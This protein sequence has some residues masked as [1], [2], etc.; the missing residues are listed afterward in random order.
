MEQDI[1][2]MLLDTPIT[3]ETTVP[4]LYSGAESSENYEEVIIQELQ[5]LNHTEARN[6]M[7]L[8][9]MCCTIILALAFKV[10]FAFLNIFKM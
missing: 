6:G 8:E 5:T 4:E 3:E 10:A 7:I 2:T 1:T 9:I